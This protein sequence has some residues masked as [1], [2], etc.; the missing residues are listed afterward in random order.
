MN[1]DFELHDTQYSTHGLHPYPAKMIPQVAEKLIQE[2]GKKATMLFDPFCGSGTTLVEARLNGIQ[3][4][5]FELNPL[6]RLIAKVKTTNIEE[7]TLELYLRNFHD[8]IFDIIFHPQNHKSVH[9]NNQDRLLLKN[10]I[11]PG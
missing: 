8:Y 6:A 1:L 11:D 7:K 10:L 3:S 4:V 2:Y 9:P 5:G